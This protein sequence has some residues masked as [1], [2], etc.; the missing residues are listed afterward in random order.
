MEFLSISQLA[1]EWG[2]SSRRIQVLCVEGRIKGA[3]K[4]GYSWVI[5]ANAEKPSDKRI[6]TGRYIKAQNNCKKK[7]NKHE[8]F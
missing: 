7:E 8:E 2:V 6:K 3:K 4:V 5:P 1:N